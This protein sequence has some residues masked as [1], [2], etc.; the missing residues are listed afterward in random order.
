MKLFIIL[1]GITINLGFKVAAYGAY[2]SKS[3]FNNLIEIDTG[4]TADVHVGYH[5]PYSA[6]R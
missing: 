6:I 3:W 1:L 5:L 4:A 2:Y